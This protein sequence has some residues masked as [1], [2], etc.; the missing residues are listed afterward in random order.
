MSRGTALIMAGG[1]G[2]HVFPALAL[3][4]VLQAQGWRV[5]WLG[6]AT[7]IEARL[8]PAWGIVLETVAV[9]GLRGKGLGRLL[10][11]PFMVLGACVQSLGVLLRQ[12]PDVVVGFG[13][14]AA[15]PGGLM[16]LLLQ[17]PLILH[18]QNAVAGLTNRLL[19]PWAKRVYEGFPK[20]FQAS[21]THPLTRCL[22][23]PRD[24]QW[25]GNPVRQDIAALAPP[26]ERFAGRAG[27]LQILVLGGSQ[28]ALALNTVI[29]QA[30]S[31]IPE[32]LR[33]RVQHQGGPRWMEQLQA[34]YAAAA[35]QAELCPFIEDM[36]GAYGACDLV[37]CRSGA[38]TVAELAAAGVGSLL[39]PFPA[40][41]DDHQRVN[42][43]FLETAGAAHVMTQ[44]QLT[45]EA[46]AHWL[47]QLT[48]P[49]LLAM[50][51]AARAMAR[52][53]AAEIMARSCAEV[54]A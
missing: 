15:F 40:A 26:E 50:A 20:A 35:V 28:G 7:G 6:T 42:A 47:R 53:Q 10:W 21:S 14:F 13:G 49:A 23:L 11:G 46:L 45:A 27:V 36:A 43:R 52:T 41:V 8:V 2:G 39:I 12:R 38:L 32:A 30:L 24:V 3:A 54:A 25:V 16:A 18:E 37:I 34:A 31:L 29:P 9:A 4:Q 48:R 22:R 5:I 19:G 1:T 51:L 17:R 44:A 33:P